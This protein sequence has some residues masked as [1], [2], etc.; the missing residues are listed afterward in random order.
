MRCFLVVQQLQQSKKSVIEGNDEVA[1]QDLQDL[2]KE[3]R[4][5]RRSTSL[6]FHFWDDFFTRVLL[7]L[8]LFISSTRLGLWNVNQYAKVEFL[9]LLFATNRSK[10]SKYMSY[11]TF[12]ISNFQMMSIRDFIMVRLFQN[13]EKGTT[14]QYGLTMSLKRQIPLE[15]GMP[16]KSLYDPLP[17]AGIRTMTEMQKTVRV[18]K[19]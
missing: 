3:F 1:L 5:A 17:K 9:P 7:P 16:H 19:M 10:Y 11:L 6:T 12:Q 14:S 2:L 18:Q 8:K 13:Y 15:D 4:Q